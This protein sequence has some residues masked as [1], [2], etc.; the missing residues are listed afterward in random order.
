MPPAE[1]SREPLFAAGRSSCESCIRGTAGGTG[2]GVWSASGPPPV[3]KRRMPALSWQASCRA[4][5]PS[6]GSPPAAHD[7][8][9]PQAAPPGRR[10]RRPE[11]PGRQILH[12]DTGTA[13]PAIDRTGRAWPGTPQP[14]RAVRRPATALRHAAANAAGRSSL[15][16]AERP[17]SCCEL[18]CGSGH[19]RGLFAARVVAP[20]VHFCCVTRCLGK[21][22]QSGAG[23]SVPHSTLLKGS[24]RISAPDSSGAE[25]AAT[26]EVCPE[27]RVCQPAGSPQPRN[28]TRMSPACQVFWTA[29]CPP[30][31][32][33][34]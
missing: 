13:G 32:S 25:T 3:A 27:T 22:Q 2:A 31:A 34:Q 5:V 15:P 33:V 11:Q 4:A 14:A 8:K 19:A 18:C 17:N 21:L 10:A 30:A 26:G 20:V 28:A 29:G 9:E 1:P 7:R 23:A 24:R 6:R 16:V 12:E